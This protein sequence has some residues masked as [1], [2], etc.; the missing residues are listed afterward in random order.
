MLACCLGQGMMNVAWH[1]LSHS[2][3][4][5]MDGLARYITP[6]YSNANNMSSVYH[7]IV[8]VLVACMEAFAGRCAWAHVWV[9]CVHASQAAMPWL[10]CIAP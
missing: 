5:G 4:L 3:T 9:A 7:A 10:A 1:C 2:P 6:P 8:C